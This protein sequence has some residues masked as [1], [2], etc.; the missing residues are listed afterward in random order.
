[1]SSSHGAPTRLPISTSHIRSC[2]SCEPDTMRVSLGETTADKTQ[3]PCCNDLHT[4]VSDPNCAVI[5]P[6]CYQ[7]R[8]NATPKKQFLFCN[9]FSI[10]L[11][12]SSKL[13]CWQTTQILCACCGSEARPTQSMCPRIGFPT[14]LPVS[15]SRI[16]IVLSDDSDTMRVLS[17][18]DG[19]AT[20][21]GPISELHQLSHLRFSTS[22]LL[23]LLSEEP[24]TTRP[25]VVRLIGSPSSCSHNRLSANFP[26]ILIVEY[27]TSTGLC[28]LKIVLQLAENTQEP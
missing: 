6:R 13:C 1:M 18:E 4:W 27:L 20:E 14:W 11:P 22:Q 16:Q 21:P 10:R 24:D 26:S 19:Y 8:E 9:G 2:P 12:V 17:G 5:R 28:G 23:I 15:V 7:V 25:N 3:F